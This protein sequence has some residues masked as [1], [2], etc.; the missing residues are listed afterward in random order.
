MSFTA[1]IA[2]SPIPYPRKHLVPEGSADIAGKPKIDL[3]FRK[4]VVTSSKKVRL[5]G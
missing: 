1:Q 5:F 3:S 2:I 4:A